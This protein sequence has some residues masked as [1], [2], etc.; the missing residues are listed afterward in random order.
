MTGRMWK[1]VGNTILEDSRT[2]RIKLV[3]KVQRDLLVSRVR[4]ERGE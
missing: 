3:V 1:Y 2:F 4:K